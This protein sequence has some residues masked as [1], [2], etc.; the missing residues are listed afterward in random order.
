LSASSTPKAVEVRKVEV[1]KAQ[2]PTKQNLHDTVVEDIE[3]TSDVGSDSDSGSDDS[4]S[5]VS[6]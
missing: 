3:D 4:D 2:T 5:D 6:L 1:A